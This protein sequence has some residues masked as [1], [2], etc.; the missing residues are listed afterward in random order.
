[1]NVHMNDEYFLWIGTQA[2]MLHATITKHLCIHRKWIDTDHWCAFI[3]KENFTIHM[4]F[5]RFELNMHKQNLSK[6]DQFAVSFRCFMGKNANFFFNTHWKLVW[7]GIDGFST[8]SVS[9]NSFICSFGFDFVD[10]KSKSKKKRFSVSFIFSQFLLGGFGS[11]VSTITSIR[12]ILLANASRRLMWWNETMLPSRLARSNASRRFSA[13][14]RRIWF[15]AGVVANLT[16]FIWVSVKFTVFFLFI[17]VKFVKRIIELYFFL[18]SFNQKKKKVQVKR[19]KKTNSKKKKKIWFI[20][21]Y[22][23]TL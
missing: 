9:F 13:F 2:T 18:F 23:S 19:K 10:S 11:P 1:M 5:E 7:L 15:Y 22:I 8:I 17:N 16:K 3:G 21:E 14:S 20:C 6:P 4:I 12:S